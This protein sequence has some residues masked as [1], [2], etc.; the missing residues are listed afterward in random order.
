MQSTPIKMNPCAC[1]CGGFTKS[2][3]KTGHHRKVKGAKPP[4][5]AKP[6]GQRIKESTIV[7]E[8]GCWEW[9]L[10]RDKDG[11]GTMKVARKTVRA[12]RAS[13]EA[14]N[15]KI[16]EG[17]V[18]NPTCKNRPCV[19][20]AHLEAVTPAESVARGDS[21]PLKNFADYYARRRAATHCPKGHPWD[22][23]NTRET[24][25]QRVCR[26]CLREGQRERRSNPDFVAR[27][28]ERNRELYKINQDEIREHK[29]QYNRAQYARAKDEGRCVF[30][31]GLGCAEPAVDGKVQCLHHLAL[32]A[33]R[34]WG[35]KKHPLDTIYK[36]R[37]IQNCWICGC[38]F[39]EET[40]MNNDHL[41][42]RSLGGPD[43]PWNL[44]PVCQSCNSRRSNL[45]LNQTMELA[46]HA[47]VAVSDF[48]EEYSHYLS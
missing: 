32:T 18:I 16:P 36:E 23:E 24:P 19:N 33:A 21:D 8:T 31:G 40:R 6:V 39:D 44:A 38:D 47:D 46:V 11:Y 1:G 41:I 29:R 30:G 34:T 9:Q 43:E 26:A 7:T 35:I 13:Y 48:P 12:G 15:G 17:Y 4:V 42:P 3:F 28:R 37:G 27:E 2:T 10:G 5:P 20:P 14:F 25:I 22:Q 45:P